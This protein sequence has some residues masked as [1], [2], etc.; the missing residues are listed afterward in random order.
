MNNTRREFVKG[1]AVAGVSVVM[2][3]GAAPA[4]PQVRA[5]AS[6]PRA[7]SVTVRDNR[8]YVETGTLSA[9]IDAGFVTSL[10]SKATGKEFIAPFDVK[11]S[12][13]LQLVYRSDE[14]VGIDE[15][16]FGEIKARQLAPDRAE[17][18]LHC[19]DGD[20]LL[21]VTADPET[22]DLICEPS[23]VSSRPGARACRWSIRALHPEL[24]LV[25]PLYQ[26]VRLKLDDPLT[27][28]RRW[29]WPAWWEAG[30][31]IFQGSGGGFWVHTRDNR[32]RY[33]AVKIGSKVDARSVGF[34]TEAY[35]PIDNSLG[36][37]GLAWRLNV[38]EGD[39]KVPAA[40][41]RDWAWQGLGLAAAERNRKEWIHKIRLAISWCPKEIEILE[42]LA[43]SVNP[44]EV[45]LHFPN[46]RSDPYDENYPDFNVSDRGRA[47]L[48][49]ARELG[50]HVM[51]HFN[52]IDIDPTNPVY[53]QVREFQYRDVETGQLKGWSWYH[54]R[55]IGVPESN[56]ARTEHRDMKVMVKIHPGLALW[57]SILCNRI[58][59]AA[60]D[61][62][63]ETVFVDVVLNTHNLQNCLVDGITPSEGMNRLVE[64]IGMLGRGLVVAGEG[65]NETMVS[66][67][68]F[69]QVHL[70]E[71]WQTSRDGL[72]RAG[73]IPMNEFLFGKVSRTFGYSSLGGRNADE[74][75]RMRIH[76]EH[77]AIPT[78]T[79]QSS[80][81]LA[82]PNNAVKKILAAAGI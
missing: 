25:A 64:E 13:A 72:A 17:V 82:N 45:L 19:W 75:L 50:Y 66:G 74:E 77:G 7:V 32:Y 57:R 6:V 12:P 37:G 34:D 28:G 73:G 3:A 26:G 41:Y 10:K 2:P 40:R 22:G 38:Y 36:A 71:S 27:A 4:A 47:F 49:R 63:L 24:E 59:K 80:A 11:S 18:F 46:W 16:R 30:F 8:V 79:I 61:L 1:M 23:A 43:K 33:K 68:S 39:W 54:D 44:K 35:G 31:A 81:E 70:F 58:A 14:G 55:S 60:A 5:E 29:A 65:L 56:A 42:V 51:P 76:S 15:S 53:Q 9:V 48:N 78:I 62:S 69:G 67:I 20:G 52:S 21:L